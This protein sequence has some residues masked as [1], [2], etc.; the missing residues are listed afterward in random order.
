MCSFCQPGQCHMCGRFLPDVRD[1]GAE[2]P[3]CDECYQPCPECGLVEEHS[4]TC[5]FDEDDD[6]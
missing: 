1:R 4:M 3:M 5:I 6:A 2:S